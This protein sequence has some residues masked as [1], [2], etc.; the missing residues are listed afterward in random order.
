MAGAM[1]INYGNFE[2]YAS[3]ISA[4]NDKLKQEL[5]DIKN[6]INSLSGEWESNS[7]V[8]IRS[9]I[10]GMQGRF[11]QYF[12]VVDNYVKVIRNAAEAY[13]QAEAANDSNANDFI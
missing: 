5:E 1:K 12:D 13:K 3:E 9:K 8:T 10:T 7:A 2:T 6:F 11:D 4:K